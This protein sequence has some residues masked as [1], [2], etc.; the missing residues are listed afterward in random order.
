MLK[1]EP[2]LDI[3]KLMKISSKIPK[4]LHWILC[5][6]LSKWKPRMAMTLSFAKQL[7][8]YEYL[9]LADKSDNLKRSFIQ[10]WLQDD[11]DFIICPGFALQAPNHGS[12]DELGSL[13]AIYNFIWN[14][15]DVPTGSIPVT[16]CR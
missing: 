6:A 10:M 5:K 7:S 13:A 4:F 9:R 14:V 15:L 12:T 2:M 8:S 1:G 3:Y 16:L 11:L